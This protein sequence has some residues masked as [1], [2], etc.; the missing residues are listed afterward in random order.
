MLVFGNVARD[1]ATEF[2]FAVYNQIGDL[3]GFDFMV[4]TGP[5][6]IF[7]PEDNEYHSGT[8]TYD[9][10]TKVITITFSTTPPDDV[11]V[12]FIPWQEGLRGPNGEWFGPYVFTT[13]V[14]PP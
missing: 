3:E 11:V 14:T 8:A 4:I 13:P 5:V 2:R 10:V 12:I 1:S 6:Q 9:D 7:V